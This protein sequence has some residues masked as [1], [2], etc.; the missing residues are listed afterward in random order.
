ML[1]L[2]LTD[3]YW[4]NV[5]YE[6]ILAWNPDYIVI[7]ADATYSADDILNDANLAGCNAVK[8]KNVVKLPNDTEDDSSSSWKLPGR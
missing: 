5:S 1:S 8:N 7:A 2:E 4:A 3:T 6:Q